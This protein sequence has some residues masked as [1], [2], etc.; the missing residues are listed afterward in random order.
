MKCDIRT[1]FNS[2]SLLAT[3]LV[4]S[5]FST[6]I[7][8][9]AGSRKNSLPAKLLQKVTKPAKE[10]SQKPSEKS[11][12]NLKELHSRYV[13]WGV[14]PENKKSSINLVDAWRKFEKK[15]DIVKKKI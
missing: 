9:A 3:A 5:T 14:D 2:K 15:K 8:L 10:I 4:V 12:F 6:S 11:Y 7:A 1:L 13:S